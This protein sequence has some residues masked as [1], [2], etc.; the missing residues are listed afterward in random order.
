[1][2]AVGQF[3]QTHERQDFPDLQ[4]TDPEQTFAGK[5]E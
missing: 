5:P 1:M 3:C 2:M 4:G